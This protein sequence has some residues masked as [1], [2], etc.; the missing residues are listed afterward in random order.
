MECPTRAL[1]VGIAEATN[2]YPAAVRPDF[3]PTV[4]IRYRAD[5]SIGMWSSIGH[6]VDTV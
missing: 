4:V 2:A 1:T 3:I 6:T 5:V